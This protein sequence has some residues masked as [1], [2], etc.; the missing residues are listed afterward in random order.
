MNLIMNNQVTGM[1]GI[2]DGISFNSV[3]AP[4]L[5]GKTFIKTHI[6]GGGDMSCLEWVTSGE[7][8]RLLCVCVT[9]TTG[10]CHFN[11]RLFAFQNEMVSLSELTVCCMFACI[12][13]CV[14]ICVCAC[15]CADVSGC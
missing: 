7:T 4:L 2:S 8:E 3:F 11:E 1:L 13:M 12:C 6:T 5:K 10:M 9:D 15:V 14:C